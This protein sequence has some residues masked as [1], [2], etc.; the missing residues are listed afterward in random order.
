MG[1]TCLL[2]TLAAMGGCAGQGPAHYDM[3]NERLDQGRTGLFA[4]LGATTYTLNRQD[5]LDRPGGDNQTVAGALARLPGVTAG[6]GGQV[7]VRGQ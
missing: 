3:V 2:V 4:P 1:R 7:R 6:P 5:L